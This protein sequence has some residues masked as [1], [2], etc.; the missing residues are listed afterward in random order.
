MYG[1]LSNA[2]VTGITTSLQEVVLGPY[3]SSNA[4]RDPKSQAL[5]SAGYLDA[6]E[7]RLTYTGGPPTELTLALYYDQARTLPL[8]GPVVLTAASASNPAGIEI[9][10][11]VIRGSVKIDRRYRLP[12]GASGNL[13]LFV[14]A[15]AGTLVAP[16]QGIHAHWTSAAG[17]ARG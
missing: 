7:F 11:G 15:D 12:D 13:H 8:A 3:D 4:T 5:P 17:G 2:E 16:A 6:L 14:R 10:G 1:H 9:S